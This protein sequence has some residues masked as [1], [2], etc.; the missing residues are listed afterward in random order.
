MN[1]GIMPISKTYVNKISPNNG[2]VPPKSIDIAAKINNKLDWRLVGM[3]GW[4]NILDSIY[5]TIRKADTFAMSKRFTS[6]ATFSN[7]SLFYVSGVLMSDGRVILVP[8]NST[9]SV[10]YNPETDS[11][12]VPTGTFAGSSAHSS[13]VLLPNGEILFIPRASACRVYNP[14]QNRLRTIGSAPAT[15][16]L[17]GVLM[18]DGRVYCIP[19]VVNGT[20]LIIDPI[21]NTTKVPTGTF[22]ASS[23]GCSLLSDGRI[24]IGS[25]A[26]SLTMGYVYNPFIDT[27]TSISINYTGSDSAGGDTAFAHIILPDETILF[28]ARDISGNS[29]LYIYDLKR[30][31]LKGSKF[32]QAGTSGGYVLLPDGTVIVFMGFS[33]PVL[34]N[35][36]NDRSTNFPNFD[37]TAGTIL[38]DGRFCS[39]PRT[40]SAFILL[41]EKGVSFSP[42]VLFSAHFNNRK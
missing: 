11:T 12:S 39:Y 23:S 6:K 1:D 40:G 8:F 20:A 33:T 21:N 22:T 3:N 34:Y 32:I 4:S 37:T 18:Q 26:N 7:G 24:F 5:D 29:R 25:Q 19:N 30:N 16:Y 9:T 10:I 27:L 31:R 14:H 17:Y 2:I 13:A 35:P 41:G 38:P 28:T 42:E 15:Q 36:L